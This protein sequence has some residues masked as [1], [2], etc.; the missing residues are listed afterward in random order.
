MTSLRIFLAAVVAACALGGGTARAADA[1]PRLPSEKPV[2]TKHQARIAGHELSYTAS[3]G[4]LVVEGDDGKPT[5]SMSYVAYTRD[6][7]GP[8]RPLSFVYN[9]GPGSSTVWLHMGA[10]G[11]RRVVT[12]NGATTPPPPYQLVDNEDSPLDASDLVFVDAPGTGYGHA[13]DAKAVFGVD[14]DAKTFAG[15]VQKYLSR[16]GR[17]NSPKFLIGESYGTTRSA[18]LVNVLAQRG[19]ACNGVVLI[20]TALD[21]ATF[22]EGPD[23][24]LPYTLFLPSLAAVA[25]YH[26]ALPQQPADLSAFL[27]EVR[28]FARTEYA[29]ALAQGDRLDPATRARIVQKLHDYTGL[30]EQYVDLANLRVSPDRFEKELLRTRRRTVGR[31]DGRFTGIDRDP[32]ADSPDYDPT[33]SAMTPVYTALFN[34][35]SR[36]ALEWNPAGEQYR[37]TDYSEVL[38]N[39]NYKRSV[40]GFAGRVLAPAVTDDLRQ[41]LSQNPA[42]RVLAVNGLYDLATPFMGTEYTLGHLGLDP[43]LVS[44]VGFAYYP[45]GHMMYADPASRTQLAADLRRFIA[46]GV[47]R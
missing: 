35:Y 24:D 39:W 9:G 11:P 33:D 44:H 40:G 21:Y 16:S 45:A 36:G 4:L 38:R 8:R 5:T 29:A 15:F 10:F 26:K 42:L 27:A 30:S 46:S 17:W 28:T 22:V 6:G 31:L 7:G 12:T 2:V 20:S 25:A 3:A 23:N 41:A 18:N 19:I 37:T 32:T 47:A 14:E 43:T 34:S 13:Y 1:P